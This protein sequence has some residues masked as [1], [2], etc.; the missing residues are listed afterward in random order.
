[1]KLHQ[2][3]KGRFVY[4]QNELYRVYAVN[5]IFKRS[6]YLMRLKDFTQKLAQAEEVTKY[7]P[8]HLDIIT[9]NHQNTRCGRIIYP[10]WGA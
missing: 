3:K 5:R 7:N 2:I 4:F 6:L 10:K 8:K 9:F 1:M